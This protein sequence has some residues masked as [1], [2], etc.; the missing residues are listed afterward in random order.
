MKK[1]IL[2]TT[3]FAI[4]LSFFFLN[5]KQAEARSYGVRNY[6]TGG[7]LRYQRGY[8]KPS[9]GQY[10]GGHFKTGPDQYK[11]NNRKSLY[12]F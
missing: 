12:G 7:V 5:S 3:I 6:K 11:W 9:T 1:I 8:F 4:V 2:T 10:I